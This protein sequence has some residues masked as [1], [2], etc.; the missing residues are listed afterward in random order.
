MLDTVKAT[1]LSSN[2]YH[3]HFDKCITQYKD[4]IKQSDGQLEVKVAAVHSTG[5]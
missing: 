3:A 5:E 1:S 4:F 2:E